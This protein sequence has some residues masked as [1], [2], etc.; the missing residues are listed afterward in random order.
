MMGNIIKL[1]KRLNLKY[2]FAQEIN[3]SDERKDNNI[4]IEHIKN[5]LSKGSAA[6]KEKFIRENFSDYFFSQLTFEQF[7][8]L[9]NYLNQH[10]KMMSIKIFNHYIVNN[11]KKLSPEQILQILSKDNVSIKAKQDIAGTYFTRI[12]S[13]SSRIVYH[14]DD[15]NVLKLAKNVKGLA[16]NKEEIDLSTHSPILTKTKDFDDNNYWIVTEKVKQL[17]SEKDF[18]SVTGI[19]FKTFCTYLRSNSEYEYIKN[20]KYSQYRSEKLPEDIVKSL[21][22]NETITEIVNL[23]NDFNMPVGDL[24][25]V[26]SWGK[27]NSNKLKLLDYGLSAD[28]LEKH[29]SR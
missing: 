15:Q 17:V 11:I 23:M 18:K 29:Y 19:D 20:Q 5:V 28:V 7:L 22:N 16:Q 25:K 9:Y 2:K 12:S 1:A 14:F 4:D 27:D 8:Y 13:G 21:Q 26:N 10:A 3:E 6:Q 24:C